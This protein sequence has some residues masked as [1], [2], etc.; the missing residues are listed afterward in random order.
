VLRGIL[1]G[2]I[3][4]LGALTKVSFF[5][6]IGLVVPLLLVI[7]FRGAGL[8]ST[9]AW[10]IAFAGAIAP[11]AIYFLRYGRSAVAQGGAASFGGL[12]DFYHVP[13]RQFLA[14]NILESPGLIV[15]LLLLA[16]AGLYLAVKKRPGLFDSDF[17]ALL[18]MIGFLFVVLAASSR[19]VR[20]LFPAIVAL[21][22]LL[23]ILLSKKES[24]VRPRL[25]GWI[26]GVVFIVLVFALM[27][28][29][30]R[31]YQQSLASAEA[32]LDEASRCNAKN[33]LL[34]TDSPSLNIFLLNLTSV[35]SS[36]QTAIQTLAYQAMSGAPIQNDFAEIKTSDLVVFQDAARLRPK[37]T[38]QRVP[39]YE[40][41]VRSAT[42]TSIRVGDDT[43]VYTK[44][45]NPGN[46]T[47]ASASDRLAC[48]P[49]C[50]K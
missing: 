1:C 29:R 20:Y 38:N 46:P 25:A 28:L 15:S 19:Q 40:R 18:I 4:S 11:T 36:S 6:F 37:F 32:V 33:V 26:T 5:Y 35:L 17:I 41:Y 23:S 22:F 44:H 13:L 34:A 10:A 7:R 8:R 48:A 39:D 47:A 16:G 2:L 42:S 50:P 43:T 14:E 49:N 12:A 3:C 27:P 9:L 31:T 21:P 30:H 24:S 45:C